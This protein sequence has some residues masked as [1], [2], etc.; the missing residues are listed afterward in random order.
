[1]FEFHFVKFWQNLVYFYRIS[2]ADSKVRVTL[3]NSIILSGS[4]RVNNP[5]MDIRYGCYHMEMF[6]W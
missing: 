4:E 6:L 1:M 2:S 5:F 3:Q